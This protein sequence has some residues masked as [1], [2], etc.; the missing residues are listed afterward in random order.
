MVGASGLLLLTDFGPLG[1]KTWTAPSV[2]F[3]T[4]L[5]VSVLCAVGALTIVVMGWRR[6][7]AEMTILG[8]TLYAASA[9]PFVHGI[10]TPDVLSGSNTSHWQAAFLAIPVALTVASPLW[11]GRRWN[12][13][14]V[15]Y[16]RTWTVGTM[17]A[18][19]AIAAALVADQD[20][21]PAPHPGSMSAYLVVG[22]SLA[23]TAALAIRQ[24]DLYE[25]G[26]RRASLVAAVGF[27]VFGLS[28]LVW[29]MAAP[30]SIGFWAAH[31]AD[32]IGVFAAIFGLGIALHRETSVARLLAPVVTRD[33]LL[34]LDLG[35]APCVHRF[36]E[37]LDSKDETTRDHVVRVGEL[38]MRVGARAGLSPRR[39][40]AL[41]LA[42]LLHDI[43]KL[44][45]PTGLLVKPGQLTTDEFE[46]IKTH[47]VAGERMLMETSGLDEAAPF[48]RS[49][50]ERPDGTGYPDGL[51]GTDIPL[52]ASI[53]SVCD[54]WDAI[55]FTRSY[56]SARGIDVARRILED[57]SGRQWSARAVALLLAE[58]DAHG[59]V[60]SPRFGHVGRSGDEG[61]ACADALPVSV[62]TSGAP[63]AQRI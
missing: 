40:R 2:L 63:L 62:G 56:Q 51:V 15:T 29:V 55:T 1:D 28:S 12:C 34:A 60:D 33:P 6:R 20:W 35:L 16:F 43:G 41:G 36:L 38:A 4:V 3:W 11:I 50:H 24:I 57:G 48:V 7:L 14:F 23:G 61:C 46:T 42:A 9:L 54:S 52:D 18:V 27:G 37:D 8:A 22:V 31:V 17:V 39:L 25:L 26:G 19:S 32:A 30:Y 13:P 10:T 21:L 49:H 59:P 58:I 53:V 44:D 5:V 45:V 47:T